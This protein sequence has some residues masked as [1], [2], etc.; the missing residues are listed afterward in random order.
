MI[1]AATAA[2]AGRALPDLGALELMA[3]D[4]HAGK[5]GGHAQEQ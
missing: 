5:E 2:P 1:F 4:A 3:F